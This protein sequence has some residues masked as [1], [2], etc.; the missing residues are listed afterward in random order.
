MRVVRK[1]LV[2]K[3][4]GVAEDGVP[5]G[6][7]LDAVGRMMEDLLEISPT[8]SRVLSLELSL[9]FSLL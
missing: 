9:Q 2:V 7:E 8:L 6:K 1:A 3:E 5:N 4:D